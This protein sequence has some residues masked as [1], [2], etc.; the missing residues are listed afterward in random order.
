MHW[1]LAELLVV[2]VW[3]RLVVLV[4]CILTG[5]ALVLKIMVGRWQQWLLEKRLLHGRPRLHELVLLLL[6]LLDKWFWL[7]H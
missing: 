5:E 1:L 7:V 3:I 2:L 6:E 4:E